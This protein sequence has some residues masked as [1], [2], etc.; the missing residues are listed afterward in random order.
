MTVDTPMT[1]DPQ[2]T[3]HGAICW[4]GN[5]YCPATPKALFTL[6]PL[7]RGVSEEE[8]AAH[9]GRSAELARYKLGRISADD[10]DGFHRSACPAI[11]GKVRCPRRAESMAL[12]ASVPRSCRLPKNPHLLH[13]KDHHRPAEH[14]RQDSPKARLPEPCPSPLLWPAQCGRA[15]QLDGQGPRFQRHLPWV[16][17]THGADLY[18]ADAH[19]PLRRAQPRILAS[20]EARWPKT[21]GAWPSG[22]H[23]ERAVGGARPSPTWS[24]PQPHRRSRTVVSCSRRRRVVPTC[25]IK[26]KEPRSRG[27]NTRSLGCTRNVKMRRLQM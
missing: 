23:H 21:N 7:A 20:F 5:L 4:N 8:T 15:F 18:D 24:R 3:H 27:P 10:A 16:V 17:P 12:S 22:S 11:A 25:S 14:Q 13:A 26:P 2:G 6:E 9:D 1:A 19:V